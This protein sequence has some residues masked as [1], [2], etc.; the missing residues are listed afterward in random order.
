MVFLFLHVDICVRSSQTGCWSRP[1]VELRCVGSVLAMV[2]KGSNI[3][4]EEVAVDYQATHCMR[5]VR[6][7][8]ERKQQIRMVCFEPGILDC[9]G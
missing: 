4:G 2:R 6:W 5:F 7:V 1:A 8:R 9:P 3:E